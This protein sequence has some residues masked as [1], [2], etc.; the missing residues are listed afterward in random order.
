MENVLIS[1][2]M[3]SQGFSLGFLHV[4]NVSTGSFS[5]KTIPEIREGVKLVHIRVFTIDHF[6]G[7]VVCL[8]IR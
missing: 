1:Q 4:M 2:E 6:I 8:W 5:L 7:C 3:L